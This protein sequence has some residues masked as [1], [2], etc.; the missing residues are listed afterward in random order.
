MAS[1]NLKIGNSDMAYNCAMIAK[2]KIDAY[3][4]S[5]SSSI[6][7][8]KE[9]KNCDT[10]IELTKPKRMGSFRLD[11]NFVLNTINTTH[12]RKVFPPKDE[13]SFT[14]DDLYQLIQTMER[15]KNDV[16][17]QAYS[18]NDFHFAE[19]MGTIFNMYK[20]PLYYI[21]E[22]YLFGRS[23]EVWV[24]GESMVPYM[25]FASNIKENTDKLV[26]MLYNANPFEPFPAIAEPLYEIL[27]D[28]QARLHLGRI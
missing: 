6:D 16:V 3:I 22:K 19:R 9:E 4:N 28:L 20:Y 8:S 18:Y 21:W 23:E 2:E 5:A 24:E 26:W 17:S 15:A 25:I 14:R 7:F 27:G 12:L 10:I 13:V 11:D 1:C